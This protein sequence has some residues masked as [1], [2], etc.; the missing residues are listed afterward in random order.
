M[1][2]SPRPWAA[3]GTSQLGAGSPADARSSFERAISIDADD[4]T[5]WADLARATS[6]TERRRALAR[7]LVLYPR[8]ALARELRRPGP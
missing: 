4:W 7:V 1:P 5:L 6:G 2:W 3:L 8:F